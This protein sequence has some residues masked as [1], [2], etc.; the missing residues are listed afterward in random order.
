ML[1][2]IFAITVS[3]NLFVVA[4]NKNQGKTFLITDSKFYVPVVPLSTKNNAKI[5]EKNK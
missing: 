2:L 4:S 5:F 3:T 1:L